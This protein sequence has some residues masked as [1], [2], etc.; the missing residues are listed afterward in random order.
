MK[1]CTFL[2]LAIQ[3][4]LGLSSPVADHV[5]STALSSRDGDTISTNPV[6]EPLKLRAESLLKRDVQETQTDI[7]KI[8]KRT[9]WSDIVISNACAACVAAAAARAGIAGFTMGRGAVSTGFF[10]SFAV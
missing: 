3:L 8:D 2:F 5:T 10:A 9:A 7:N 4:S 6:D 1:L